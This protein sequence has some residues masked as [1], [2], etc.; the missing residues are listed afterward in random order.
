[1]PEKLIFWEKPFTAS[2]LAAINTFRLPEGE[3]LP[4]RRTWFPKP[5]VLQQD[6]ELNV[7]E[8][9][10]LEAKLAGEEWAGRSRFQGHGKHTENSGCQASH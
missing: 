10:P 2:V 7:D 8:P 4:N 5:P 3:L 6:T 9:G 1:M